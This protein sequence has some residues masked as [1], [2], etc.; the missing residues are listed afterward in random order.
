[1]YLLQRGQWSPTNESHARPLIPSRPGRGLSLPRFSQS[2]RQRHRPPQSSGKATR[3][4]S[5]RLQQQIR[6]AHPKASSSIP[7]Q[8]RPRWL[9]R[10]T[11]SDSSFYRPNGSLARPRSARCRRSAA[12]SPSKLSAR[13]FP[14]RD[15]RP[16]ACLARR[17]L[18]F[19]AGRRKN[20]KRVVLAT[21]LAVVADMKAEGMEGIQAIQ[22][23]Q[24]W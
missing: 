6:K 2:H 18:P 16:P 13:L 15:A 7:S 3:Q 24:S 14:C 8:P 10:L 21:P 5:H 4:G 20:Y 23:S 9:S 1:M 12:P 17:N 11:A 22:A 19:L